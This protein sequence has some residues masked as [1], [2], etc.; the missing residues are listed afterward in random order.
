MPRRNR[1]RPPTINVNEMMK[2]FFDEATPFLK[3]LNK[4]FE[5]FAR[6][7]EGEKRKYEES[8]KVHMM[9]IDEAAKIL[10]I[11]KDATEDEIKTAFRNLAKKYHPY[12]NK[13]P[14]ASA[15]F[16]KIRAAYEVMNNNAKK[17]PADDED[18]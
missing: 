5:N 10:G 16:M 2:D 18:F 1:R 4:T 9:E 17:E 11:N 13:D 6:I 7:Y 12:I 15:K 3:E 14:R 8:H